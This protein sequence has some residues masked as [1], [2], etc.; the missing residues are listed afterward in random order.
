MYDFKYRQV[1]ANSRQRRYKLLKPVFMVFLVAL[2]LGLALSYVPD[3]LGRK[4]PGGGRTRGAECHPFGPA[5]PPKPGRKLRVST[6]GLTRKN[7]AEVKAVLGVTAGVSNPGPCP[8]RPKRKNHI[9]RS[10]W[11]WDCG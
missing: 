5:P 8:I 11:R 1:E 7:S 10:W 6:S 3:W 4:I 2:A 9:R